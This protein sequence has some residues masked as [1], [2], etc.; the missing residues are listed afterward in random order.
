[1]PLPENAYDVFLQ[2][3]KDRQI[4]TAFHGSKIGVSIDE[5]LKAPLVN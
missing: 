1:M 4:G 2:R 3:F 5:L